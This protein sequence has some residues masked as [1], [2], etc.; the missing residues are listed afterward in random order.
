MK[1]LNFS[2]VGLLL[3]ALLTAGCPGNEPTAP[4]PGSKPDNFTFEGTVYFKDG[5]TRVANLAYI[6]E[7]EFFFTDG[8]ALR[9]QW[10]YS[11]YTNGNGQFAYLAENA[12]LGGALP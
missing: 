4:A 8:M 5:K 2:T 12:H 6:Y 11:D 9:W 7:I 1:A 10:P 3:L